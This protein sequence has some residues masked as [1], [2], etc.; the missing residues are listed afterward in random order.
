MTNI[1]KDIVDPFYRYQREQVKISPQRLG[2]KI[3]N[4]ELL[5]GDSD[6]IISKSLFIYLNVYC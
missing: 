6:N 1:P 4:L 3:D 5:K 2:I